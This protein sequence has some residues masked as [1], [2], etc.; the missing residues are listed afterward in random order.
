VENEGLI[1]LSLYGASEVWLLNGRVNDR[2]L[3]VF[4]DSEEAVKTY[5]DARWL[6]HGLGEGFDL[7][8]SGGDLSPDIA[9]TQ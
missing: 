2:V 9:V 4:K 3:M 5:I 7:H 8:P 1:T 6:D